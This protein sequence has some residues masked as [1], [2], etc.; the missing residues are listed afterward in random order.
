MAG[1][2]EARLLICAT[3]RP[4]IA[5]RLAFCIVIACSVCLYIAILCVKDFRLLRIT[6]F[7]SD[8]VRRPVFYKLRKTTFRKLDLFPSSG[9][10]GGDGANGRHKIHIA[11]V[12]LTWGVQ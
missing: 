11:V 8:F 4:E 12:T 7:F 9:E 5:S 1:N 3:A 6:V 2:G 10:G